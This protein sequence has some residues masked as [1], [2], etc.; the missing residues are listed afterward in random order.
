[1]G[2]H[3]PKKD[4]YDNGNFNRSAGNKGRTQQGNIA[5]AMKEYGTTLGNNNTGRNWPVP[6]GGQR[7]I[8]R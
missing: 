3:N 7:T 1:M 5:D 8:R 6:K 4:Y 2:Y